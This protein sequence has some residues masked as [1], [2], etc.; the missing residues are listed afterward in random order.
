MH[1]NI[2]WA[3][4]ELPGLSHEDLVKLSANKLAS[5]ENGNSN[6][7]SGL[8]ERI[9]PLATKAFLEGDYIGSQAFYERSSK[10]GKITYNLNK[11][12][13]NMERLADLK[14]RQNRKKWAKLLLDLKLEEFM[15]AAVRSTITIKT[16][17]NITTR[18]ELVIKT[19]KMGGYHNVCNYY[20]LN[21]DAINEALNDDLEFFK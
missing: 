5:I 2:K 8:L 20:K 18:S 17:F 15:P 16:W 4:K 13:G 9:R 21:Y 14:T 7:D 12:N 10:G 11:E 19:D 3:N 6:R 1:K